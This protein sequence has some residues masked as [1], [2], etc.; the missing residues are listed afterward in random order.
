MKS[1][2]ARFTGVLLVL[3]IAFVSVNVFGFLKPPKESAKPQNSSPADRETRKK[4]TLEMVFVIDTTG[5]MGGLIEGAKQKIW[6]IVNGVMSEKDRPNVKIGLVAY[7]DNKDEYVTKILPLTDDL[8]KVYSVLMQYQADGGGDTPE[9]VRRALADGVHK[10]GWSKKTK[11]ISQILF[12]VGDAP[13][14]EDYVQEPDVLKTTQNAVRKKMI[15]N[16]IQCGNI[17]GTKEIWQKIA[18][19]GK[20]KYF[21]IA[22]N[23]GVQIIS[24]PYDKKLSE[25]GTKLGSTYLA[26]GGGKGEAGRK[27]RELKMV[28]QEAVEDTVTTDAS[29]VAQADRAVN[30]AINSTA[31]VNDLLQ[32][33]ENESIK[34]EDVKEE[35]LPELLKKLSPKERRKEVEKRLT[36][37]KNIRAEIMELSKKRDEY[38]KAERSKTGTKN[39]FDSAVEEALREQMLRK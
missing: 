29:I 24:T 4:R 20:G 25:L 34:L 30:K 38:L 23:G 13:P 8:D 33:I 15:L 14:H 1:L 27:Y 7:R 32:A 3:M 28:A 35:D 21:A 31:Y 5:S 22:Q 9:N 12:L 37:R 16:T 26:Y 6:S 10:T 11:N 19:A 18:L 36:E 2:S 17:S 39:G